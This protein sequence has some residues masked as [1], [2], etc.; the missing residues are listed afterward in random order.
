M[1]DGSGN[2]PATTVY[3]NQNLRI[4]VPD[5]KKPQIAFRPETRKT[6][7]AQVPSPPPSI[8]QGQKHL[9][10]GA[11]KSPFSYYHLNRSSVSHLIS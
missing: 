1:T 8:A 5:K 4:P 6:E 2:V 9:K 10:K 7:L 11:L 3:V